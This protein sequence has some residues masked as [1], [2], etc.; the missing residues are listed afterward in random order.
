[1]NLK[2]TAQSIY[3]ELT[4]RGIDVS[5]VRLNLTQAMVFNYAGK[6]RV[7]VGSNP[8]IANASFSTIA[9]NKN[10]T[11]EVVKEHGMTSVP[12]TETFE[13]VSQAE[14]FLKVNKRIVIKP[15]DGAH[16]NGVTTNIT[17]PR[18][19]EQAVEAALSR[20]ESEKILLQK[21]IDGTDLRVL[22]I[23][24]EC[25]GVVSR[26]PAR[27]VGDGES[28]VL[29]LIEHENMHNS[30]RGETPYTKKM[31]KIDIDAVMRFLSASQLSYVP[32]IGEIFQVVGTANIGTGGR[33]VECYGIVPEAL[34]DQAI[35]ISN[36]CGAFI[37]GVDFLYDASS[38]TWYL[39]EI[40]ASPSFGLH[41]MPSE[42]QP[43]N[44]LPKLYVDK[45]LKKYNLNKL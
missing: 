8:D 37:A 45:L 21:Q 28:T 15:V 31:N 5:I 41:M 42:G 3:Q 36:V 27:V 34:I 18:Q 35:K 1:M 4:E 17:K 29:E 14:E 32:G 19:I 43:I 22:V 30:D 9:Q 25:V 10:F 39:L 33:S 38:R 12:E 2:I 13:S 44:N 6:M 26:E 20:S 23:D 40:N 16:G 7:I 11:Y 24:N